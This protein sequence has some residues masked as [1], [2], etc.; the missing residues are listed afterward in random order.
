MIALKQPIEADTLERLG[1]HPIKIYTFEGPNLGL[2]MHKNMY[3]LDYVLSF[4][5]NCVKSDPI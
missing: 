2:Y 5:A 1:R 4:V 3:Y